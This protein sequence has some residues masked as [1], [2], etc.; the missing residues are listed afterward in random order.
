MTGPLAS[1]RPASRTERRDLLRIRQLTQTTADPW[2][3]SAAL[4]LTASALIV[5][6]V[7]G[8]VLLR[9]H[10]RQRAWLQVG[11]HAGPGESD[12][13]S[14]AVRE[15]V[16]ETGLADLT[17]WPDRSVRHVVIVPVEAGRGEPAHEHADIRFVLATDS[18]AAI[19]AEHAAA[20][21][22]WLDPAEAARLTSEQ[23]LRI[24]LARLVALLRDRAAVS[25][26]R[27][28]GA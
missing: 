27:L 2:L 13:L 12:P 1:Y 5:H 20:P 18:P 7:S 8:R 17:P 11:G 21:L 14:I 4:H 15:A 24:T 23:N 3:R 25:G 26:Q 10:P 16:E 6:P 19:R 22:R 9:W 28:A